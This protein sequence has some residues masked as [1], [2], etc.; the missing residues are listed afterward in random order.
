MPILE[1]CAS[2]MLAYDCSLSASSNTTFSTCI[3]AVSQT[4][5]LL[6]VTVNASTC[7]LIQTMTVISH[8]LRKVS[9]HS[10][11][12]SIYLLAA[13]VTGMERGRAEKQREGKHGAW[14]WDHVVF[15]I[16]AAV[17]VADDCTSWVKATF[18][19]SINYQSLLD[20]RYDASTVSESTYNLHWAHTQKPMCPD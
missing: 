4:H 12:V 14:L 9:T 3:A 10:S 19:K 15:I 1:S 17:C 8:H 2:S 20:C 11:A 6:H 5:V 7:H 16:V 13:M 18:C